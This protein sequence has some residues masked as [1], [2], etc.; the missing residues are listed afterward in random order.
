MGLVPKAQKRR[1]LPVVY[2][3][4]WKIA[5]ILHYLQTGC[6]RDPCKGFGA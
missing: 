5:K 1:Y 3:C 2:M 4:S 6:G